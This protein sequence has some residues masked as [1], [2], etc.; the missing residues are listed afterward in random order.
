M[1]IEILNLNKKKLEELGIVYPFDLTDVRALYCPNN[2]TTFINLSASQWKV[3]IMLSE[4]FFMEMFSNTIIHESIHNILKT[5]N[6]KVDY[7][8]DGEERV[9]RIMAGQTL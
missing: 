2:D 5:G 8:R 3:G 1:K 6:R 9:C 4:D 7:T